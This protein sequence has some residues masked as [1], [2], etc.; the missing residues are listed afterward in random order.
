MT[1]N[2]I[3]PAIQSSTVVAHGFC[4]IDN[5]SLHYIITKPTVT[6]L[7]TETETYYEQSHF[8]EVLKVT[9]RA[10]NENPALCQRNERKQSSPSP[11]TNYHQAQNCEPETREY[12]EDCD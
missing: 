3:L 12:Y 1:G 7:Q 11:F 9:N 4:P 8:Q 5:V 6:F 10:E 2:K